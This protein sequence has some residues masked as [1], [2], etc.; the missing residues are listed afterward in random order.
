[1]ATLVRECS[2]YMRFPV[3]ILFVFV[4]VGCSP[5]TPRPPTSTPVPT[6]PT[7]RPPTA[8][9]APDYRSMRSRLVEPLSAMIVAIR[10]RDTNNAAVFYARFNQAGDEVLASISSDTSK[11]A[12]ALHS[13][14]V[15]VRT[16]PNNLAALE[17]DRQALIAAIP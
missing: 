3:A 5:A 6:T 13:A 15:N 17:D 2:A 7:P 8:T 1:M 11:S 10:S 14:V 9:P 12:N 16:H 4:L